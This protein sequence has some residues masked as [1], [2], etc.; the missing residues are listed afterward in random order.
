MEEMMKG[1]TIGEKMVW[2]AAFVKA[3]DMGAYELH[4]SSAAE[5]A[6]YV[7]EAMREQLTDVKEGYEGC[8]PTWPTLEEMLK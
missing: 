7:V 3:L 4:I 2:A 6:A 8:G 5:Q 1:M